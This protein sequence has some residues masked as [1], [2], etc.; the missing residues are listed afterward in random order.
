MKKISDALTDFRKMT[1]SLSE[2][3][4]HQDFHFDI[5]VNKRL[6]NIFQTGDYYYYIYNLRSGE[7]ELVSSEIEPVLGYRREDVTVK[8]ILGS[9]HP[10]DLPWFLNFENKV[11][12]FFKEL[13][14][15]QILKYK[16]RY[17][18]R[19]RKANG[20]YI[21][22]LQQVITLD[23]DRQHGGV[24]RTLG[25]HTDITHLK[26]DG[27]PVLSFIGLEDEPSY[28]DVVVDKLFAPTPSLI[29]ER[30]KEV[31]FLLIEGKSSKEI[32]KHLFISI[33]TVNKHRKNILRKTKTSGTPELIAKTVRNGWV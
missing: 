11:V 21:R 7:F 3:V 4:L 27:Q 18:Y 6:L 16:V 22:I 20:D 23:Y 9:I 1:A 13:Q 19:V 8:L 14:P 12:E 25:V 30:E 15:H 32:A 24:L 17:D 29:S 28:V 2:N 5:D 10:E 33:E 26:K 31:L